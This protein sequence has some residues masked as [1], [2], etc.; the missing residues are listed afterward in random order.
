MIILLLIYYII[1]Y[2]ILYIIII[3]YYYYYILLLLYIILL[4]NI[5][6]I[7]FMMKMIEVDPRRAG[8]HHVKL[9]AVQG[10]F[11]VEGPHALK[12]TLIAHAS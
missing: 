9:Y 10:K 7:I 11:F 4:Y 2:Y 1:F 3:I 12:D 5:I 6:N 8:A